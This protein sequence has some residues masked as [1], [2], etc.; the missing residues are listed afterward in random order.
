MKRQ[1]KSVEARD[2]KRLEL[3]NKI[4]RALNDQVDKFKEAQEN[5]LKEI[6]KLKDDAEKSYKQHAEFQ[7]QILN[8]VKKLRAGG[9]SDA[10]ITA[11]LKKNNDY[12]Q[13]NHKEMVDSLSRVN[14]KISDLT[15]QDEF[16]N[17]AL[18]NSER[19]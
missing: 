11:Y 2:K 7:K 17:A 14:E 8:D 9:A 19:N 13:E 6:Q 15:K 4:A 18:N 5:H 10:E 16:F 3:D 1:G 12:F